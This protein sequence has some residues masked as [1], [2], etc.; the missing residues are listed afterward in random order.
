[1]V[2]PIR[3]SLTSKEAELP[4]RATVDLADYVV[5]YQIDAHAL[6]PGRMRGLRGRTKTETFPSVH[7]HD[8]ETRDLE[9]ELVTRLA[10]MKEARRDNYIGQTPDLILVV[11]AWSG[12]FRVMHSI[13]PNIAQQFSRWVDVAMVVDRVR[14]PESL[15]VLSVK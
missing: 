12:E 13:F 7:F 11:F 3:S 6:A 8:M 14:A 5:Q 15:N 9:Q 10:A 2:Q 1:M 4:P